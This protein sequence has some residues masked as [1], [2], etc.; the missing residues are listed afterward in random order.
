MSVLPIAAQIECVVNESGTG[1]EFVGFRSEAVVIEALTS[2]TGLS[3]NGG[4]YSVVGVGDL[5]IQ[6]TDRLI[7]FPFDGKIYVRMDLID[8]HEE[9][10][11]LV[12]V[13]KC[14]QNVVYISV[15]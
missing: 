11:S 1:V 2:E 12:R 9:L 4:R 3:E 7:H 10:F 6:K 5:Y 14:S 8:V 13:V 15:V